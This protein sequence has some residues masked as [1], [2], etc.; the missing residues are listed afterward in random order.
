M[1]IDNNSLTRTPVNPYNAATEKAVTARRPFQAKKKPVK[2]ATVVQGWAGSH[3][4]LMVGQWMS[5]AR[6][7]AP[8]KGQPRAN[9]S[10][11]DLKCA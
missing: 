7:N 10:G 11:R 5:G 6:I 9:V 3:E 8:T 2:R 1:R 4:A